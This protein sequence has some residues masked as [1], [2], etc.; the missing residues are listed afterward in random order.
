MPNSAHE[1]TNTP[2]T[3]CHETRTEM[4][5]SN[6]VAMP[7]Q[8]SA[9]IA[10]ELIQ[11]IG[12]TITAAEAA[13][14]WLEHQPPDLEEARQML[15]QIVQDS[16]RAAGIVHGVRALAKNA[17]PMS[18][19][20]LLTRSSNWRPARST[21]HREEA[22]D[23][24]PPPPGPA[25]HALPDIDPLN[26]HRTARTMSHVP[27]TSSKISEPPHVFERVHDRRRR[28]SSE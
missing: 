1:T 7:G 15:A 28:D 3:M 20:F 14:R 18:F 13:L 2:A 17:P 23:H 11:P 12:A 16:T 9:S 19:P 5:H 4:V 25:H 22:S 8:L 21:S 10:D 24:S 27:G 26:A 6:R